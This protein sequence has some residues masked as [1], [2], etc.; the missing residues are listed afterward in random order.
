MSGDVYRHITKAAQRRASI[1]RV[2]KPRVTF[3]RGVTGRVSSE[4]PR[5]AMAKIPNNH[6]PTEAQVHTWGGLTSGELACGCG[7]V[8]KWQGR[9]DIGPL[10]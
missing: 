2:L 4:R 3:E 7:H 1:Q 5:P 10:Q 6:L 8:L 9:D